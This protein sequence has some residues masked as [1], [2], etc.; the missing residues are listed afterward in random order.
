MTLQCTRCY[1]YVQ[2]RHVS[3]SHEL[4]MER[5][6]EKAFSERKCVHHHYER[7][8]LFFPHEQ[9]C[10]RRCVSRVCAHVRVCVSVYVSVCVSMYVMCVCMCVCVYACV[11]VYL[12]CLCLLC[13]CMCVCMYFVCE[14]VCMPVFV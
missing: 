14:S 9:Q 11:C 3:W 2:C 5:C 10:V 12:V 7:V 8:L 1:M 13:L 6:A 4:F